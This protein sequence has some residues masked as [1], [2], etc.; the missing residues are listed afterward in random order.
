MLHFL[1]RCLRAIRLLVLTGIFSG[2]KIDCRKCD[3]SLSTELRLLGNGKIIV[4]DHITTYGSVTIATSGL[5]EIEYASF[6]RYDIIACDC[7]IKIGKKCIF[8]PMVMIYDH[9]HCFDK[10]GVIDG[11]TDGEVI[12]GD[13]VWV[14]A[15]C[16]ILKNTHIGNNSIIGAGCVVTGNIPENSLVTM[17]RTLIIKPL[18]D[19]TAP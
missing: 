11:Y 17:D 3:I 2:L 13:N 8:G 1:Y 10:N 4:G 12:I 5:V 14:G 15:N 19:K 9:D 18:T 7:H 6:N 16:V